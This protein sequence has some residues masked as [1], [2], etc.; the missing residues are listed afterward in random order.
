MLP[1]FGVVNGSS[2]YDQFE[3][4]CYPEFEERFISKAPTGGTTEFPSQENPGD[5]YKFGTCEENGGGVP[6]LGFAKFTT[7]PCSGHSAFISL[8][9]TY[10]DAATFFG[11]LKSK[12]FIDK[13]TRI[14]II[15]YFVYNANL[16]YFVSIKNAMEF[17]VGGQ[18]VPSWDYRIFK[19][20]VLRT[21]VDYL[22]FAL[23]ILL[24]LFVAFYVYQ[25]VEGLYLAYVDYRDG[26]SGH[27]INY[28]LAPWV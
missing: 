8:N 10:D 7:Y 21:P 14:V 24:P 18:A 27:W 23:S 11:D 6:Y 28:I 25:Y 4:V 9:D 16:N 12:Y 17:P 19:L 3:Q 20:E 22:Q 5:L 26:H 2:V 13:A 15:E 1:A